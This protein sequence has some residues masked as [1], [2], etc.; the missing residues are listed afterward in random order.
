M[1]LKKNGKKAKNAAENSATSKALKPEAKIVKKVLDKKSPGTIKGKDKLKSAKSDEKQKTSLLTTE[2]SLNRKDAD[3]GKNLAQGDS[4]NKVNKD[5]KQGEST[6]DGRK[7]GS[8]NKTGG[9][10]GKNPAK[11]DSVKEINSRK[12]EELKRGHHDAGDKLGGLIFMCNSRTKPDCFR[13]QIMA[14]PFNQKG[15]VLGIKPGLKLFLYDF[16]LKLMHGIYEA[17]SSG[18]LKLEP[19]AFGGAFPAQIRFKVYKDC[20]P[21]PESVFKKAIMETYDD[22]R[23]RFKTD[24]SVLQVKK[25]SVLFRPAR[26]AG[27]KPHIVDKPFHT[28]RSN[29]PKSPAGISDEDRPRH[30]EVS[31]PKSP[32]LTEEQYRNFGLQQELPGANLFVDPNP[33]YRSFQEKYRFFG[34]SAPAHAK[35]ASSR[36]TA[37]SLDPFFLTEEEYRIYG[38][39]DRRDQASSIAPTSLP[40]NGSSHPVPLDYSTRTPYH[41]SSSDPDLH[42]RGTPYSY[43]FYPAAETCM[44]EVRYDAQLDADFHL[45][46]KYLHDGPYSAYPATQLPEYNRSPPHIVVRSE[47]VSVP[48]SSCYL[49]AGSPH[50]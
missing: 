14:V 27:S 35:I 43:S 29:R 20:E 10:K 49:F 45:Y 9:G 24:L 28:S 1:T 7:E 5:E 26:H 39:R 6:L 23:R 41:A 36:G 37:A 2:S 31:Y 18:G 50:R 25:L 21:L 47:H 15:T 8:Q 19:A 33:N 42:L 40:T 34:G 13:Y 12:G 48:V 16:D 3:K 11:V 30:K 32:F 46:I 4:D 44:T 17:S 22:R 38:L